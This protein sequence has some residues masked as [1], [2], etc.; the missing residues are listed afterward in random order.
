MVGLIHQRYFNAY[1]NPVGG[2]G[3]EDENVAAAVFSCAVL[4]GPATAARLVQ[5]AVGVPQDGKVG[6]QTLEAINHPA[7]DQGKVLAA[8]TLARIAR[9]TAICNNDR[10][11]SK[12]L[13]GWINRALGEAG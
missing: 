1:W 7:R 10:S 2:D 5:I 12:F 11:Q 4:S 3:I 8:F 13:L 6:P 9:Y